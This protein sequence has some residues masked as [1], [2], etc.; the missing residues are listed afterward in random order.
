MDY[1]DK[2]ND[3]A[4]ALNKKYPNGNEPFQIMTRLTEETGE[5]AKEVN[6]FEKTGRKV[7]KYGEPDKKKL[8]SE[9]RDVIVTTLQVVQYYKLDEEV[10]E[11]IDERLER[12]GQD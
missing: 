11:V 6:H 4:K 9:I 5:L 3:I 10:K 7:E 2:L 12:L 8:A 1:Y